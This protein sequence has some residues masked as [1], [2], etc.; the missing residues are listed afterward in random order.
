MGSSSADP[1][2]AT[3]AK[4]QAS[5]IMKA[6]N[7]S[8]TG[9][10]VTVM[11]A[12]WGQRDVTWNLSPGSGPAQSLAHSRATAEPEP[13]APV[14]PTPHLLGTATRDAGD[15]T[16][17]LALST[18]SCTTAALLRATSP[19]LRGRL[20]LHGVTLLSPGHLEVTGKQ[21]KHTAPWD[22]V[23]PVE[24]PSRRHCVQV[25]AGSG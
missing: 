7:R 8:R 13:P 4:G 9:N 1:S 21:T 23:L 6:A 11:K 5:S 22:T 16:V 14:A 12:T 2:E 3:S 17:E 15:S 20:P 10:R 18:Q 25:R 24:A 19:V